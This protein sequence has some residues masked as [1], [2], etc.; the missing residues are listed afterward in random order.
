ML[1]TI[2]TLLAMSNVT[3]Q[4]LQYHVIDSHSIVHIYQFKEGTESGRKE[5]RSNQFKYLPAIK[6][7]HKN[8]IRRVHYAQGRLLS[9]F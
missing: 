1:N 5:L 9:C 6:N 3:A 4:L 8:I 7:R 2:P